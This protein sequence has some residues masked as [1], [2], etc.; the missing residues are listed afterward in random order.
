MKFDES[1]LL[2]ENAM[3]KSRSD[4]LNEW[5]FEKNDKL[6]LDIYKVTKGM[7]IKVW[8]ICTKCESKFFMSINAR[9]NKKSNCPYCAGVRVNNTNSL[10]TKDKE[11]SSQWNIKKNKGLSPYEVLYG[12]TYKYWWMCELGHE[13]EASIDN[14]KKGQGCP[15]CAKHNAKMLVGFNDMWTT[16][17]EL[18]SYLLNPEHGYKYMRRSNVKL[19]WKC[20]ICK[21]VVRNVSPGEVGS[22][23][24]PCVRCSRSISLGEKFLYA[25]LNRKNISFKREKSFEWSENKRYDF[26]LHDYNAIIEVHGDQHYNKGSGTWGRLKDIQSNDEYK[27]K[28]AIDNGIEN[29]IVINA[30][31]SDFI[32]LRDSILESSLKL[33][34]NIS[35]EDIDSI[36]YKE[37][38]MIYTNLWHMW[39][40]GKSVAD[41]AI[42]LDLDKSTVRK[43]L[44]LG[45][46]LGFCE[47]VV[48]KEN[49]KSIIRGKLKRSKKVVKLD[50][51]NNYIECFDSIKD[52]GMS[53]NHKSGS[54]IA[55]CCKGI[56]KT[57]GGFKWMYK[58]DYERL[59]V[60]IINKNT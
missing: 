11:M 50:E 8:W 44:K 35:I 14:R 55:K 56:M 9:T 6:G 60:V 2:T 19:N 34:L 54:S 27:H 52:A 4:L 17:P 51:N 37:V 40:N 25:L 10:Y 29:Y 30:S 33:L 32:Y 41:I 12:G 20:G 13:W 18:A 22:K 24:V 53:L 48:E 15:Y 26:Y 16:D 23:G 1:I 36:K 31:R 46:E 5:D 28:I 7:G 3:L 43:Y 49:K 42:E 45:N 21:A 59:K 58:D 38:D 39:E 57:S 47:Y